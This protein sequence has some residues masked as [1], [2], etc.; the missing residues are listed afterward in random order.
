LEDSHAGVRSAHAAGCMTVM[1]P[2]LLVADDEMR[3]R[4]LV[5]TSLLDVRP[6]L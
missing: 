4:A 5:V 3:E 1:I 2:D 6:L